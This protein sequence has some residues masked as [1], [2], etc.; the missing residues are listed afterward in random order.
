MVVEVKNI[1]NIM[2][3]IL[4]LLSQKDLVKKIFIEYDIYL[5]TDKIVIIVDDYIDENNLRLIL[6]DFKK[7]KYRIV[8]RNKN[9]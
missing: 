7:C 4:L 1:Q 3:D 9:N 8:F 5:K 2:E 6:D